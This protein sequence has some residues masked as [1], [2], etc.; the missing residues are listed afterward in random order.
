MEYIA[1]SNELRKINY[2]IKKG[3]KEIDISLDLGKTLSKIQLNKDEIIFDEL[4]AFYQKYPVSVPPF[5]LPFDGPMK[6]RLVKMCKL[7]V[8]SFEKE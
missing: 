8:N 7:F 2:A 3:K 1:S 6:H 5:W 4:C